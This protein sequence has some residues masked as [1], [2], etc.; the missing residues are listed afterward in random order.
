MR[1]PHTPIGNAKVTSKNT[2]VLSKTI[3]MNQGDPVLNQESM[4]LLIQSI[5]NIPNLTSSEIP[6]IEFLQTNTQ[7]LASHQSVSMGIAEYVM[8]KSS[9]NV[10]SQNQLRVL[11]TIRQHDQETSENFMAY[12]PTGKENTQ[13]VFW[14]DPTLKRGAR[15]IFNEIPA[16]KKFKIIDKQTPIGSGGCCYQMWIAYNLQAENFNYVVTEPDPN[17]QNGLSPASARWGILFNSATYK[18]LLEKTFE[19][20]ML[21]RLLWSTQSKGKTLYCDPF[22]EDVNFES[23]EEYE[24]NYYRHTELARKAMMK[25][26]V[27]VM[28]LGMNEVW[29]L[30]AGGAALSRCPW[31]LSSSLL[32][33]RTLTVEENIANLQGMLNVWRKYNPDIKIIVAVSPVPEHAT[34]LAE[35]QHVICANSLGKSI[36]RI[37][38][39]EFCDHNEGVYY[40]PVYESVMHC[41]EKP[42]DDDQR[43]V[44]TEGKDKGAALFHHMFVKEE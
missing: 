43:H 22:R 34:F 31:G 19:N 33:K 42:W 13:G 9:A 7:F 15:N 12:Y 10:D 44:S 20:L 24:E 21:P 27:F 40:Y 4:E 26:K 5:L 17:A 8:K 25:M 6:L 14:P 28:T 23:I 36:L 35:T 1:I 37:A 29:Y 11:E 3:V 39:Q 32:E 16:A 30:R 38:A 41:T 18:Q 2:R